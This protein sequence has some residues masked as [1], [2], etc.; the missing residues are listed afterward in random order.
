MSE[1]EMDS[2]IGQQ[3]DSVDE[4]TLE[5]IRGAIDLG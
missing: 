4:K 1:K 2:R 5:L 3:L